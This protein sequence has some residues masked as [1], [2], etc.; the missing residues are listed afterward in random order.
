MRLISQNLV[1]VSIMRDYEQSELLRR[2]ILK[3]LD[4]GNVLR[5][6]NFDEVFEN[7]KRNELHNRIY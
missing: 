3:E 1:E 2:F 7:R 5:N 4:P 6:V